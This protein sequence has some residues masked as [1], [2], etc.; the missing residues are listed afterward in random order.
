MPAIVCVHVHL[1]GSLSATYD[2]V[3][4]GPEMGSSY[5]IVLPKWRKVLLAIGI[6]GGKYRLE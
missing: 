4:E 6:G 3:P 1:M 2:K 5:Q